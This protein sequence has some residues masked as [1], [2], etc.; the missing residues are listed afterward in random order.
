MMRSWKILAK[1]YPRPSLLDKYK[2]NQEGKNFSHVN[3][4]EESLVV[5]LK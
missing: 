3:C 5:Y 1:L 4:I 2:Q